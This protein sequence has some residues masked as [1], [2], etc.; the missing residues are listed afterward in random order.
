M[1]SIAPITFPQGGNLVQQPALSGGARQA[2][3]APIGDNT[4]AFTPTS[5]GGGAQVEQTSPPPDFSAMLKE[6]TAAG[7]G[8]TQ[9]TQGGQGQFQQPITPSPSPAYLTFGCGQKLNQ[10]A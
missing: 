6:L 1:G 9:S 4:Q 7:A 8:A 3:T 5:L 2:L 10:L